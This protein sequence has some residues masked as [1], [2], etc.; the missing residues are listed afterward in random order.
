[1][2]NIAQEVG[3]QLSKFSDSLFTVLST[4]SL[5]SADYY[6]LSFCSIGQSQEMVVLSRKLLIVQPYE[7]G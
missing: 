3:S 6:A 1:M 2:V 4:V 5:E 7:H